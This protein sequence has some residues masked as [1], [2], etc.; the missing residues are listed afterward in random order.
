MPS[1]TTSNLFYKELMDFVLQNASAPLIGLTSFYVG[2]LLTGSTQTNAYQNSF[3]EV[4]ASRGY[5]RVQI[6]R[7]STTSGGVAG[8]QYNSSNLEY[9]NSADIVFG[10]PTND[11]GTIV[12]VGLFKSAAIGNQDM[13]YYA[14]LTSQKTVNNG[15]GA[16]KILAGQL[17]IARATC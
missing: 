17:R 12:A 10:V 7:S 3:S 13:I 2:L 4:Q 6:N 9:S 16:P 8:W 5:S 11:W 15:D 14:G 1:A